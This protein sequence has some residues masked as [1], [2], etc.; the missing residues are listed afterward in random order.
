MGKQHAVSMRKHG[1]CNGGSSSPEYQAW[2]IAKHRCTNP[3]SR[4]WKRYGERGIIMCPRWTAS[5]E[6]FLEDVGPRPEGKRE[7]GRTLYSLD[8]RD[9][10]RGY[11]CGKCEACITS[12]LTEPNCRWATSITQN[13]NTRRTRT[14]TI[15]GV[16]KPLQDWLRQY[17]LK[18]HVFYNRMNHGFTPAD[19]ITTPLKSSETKGRRDGHVTPRPGAES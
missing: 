13:N 7:D 6:A 2:A 1:H 4:N 16:T 19:A 12:G 11:E 14:V 15:D 9:N 5:F 17:G 3:N 18:G 8:R 10:S